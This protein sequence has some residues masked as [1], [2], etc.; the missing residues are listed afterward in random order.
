MNRALALAIAALA[1]TAQAV[2][3]DGVDIPQLSESYRDRTIN[4]RSPLAEIV[5]RGKRD[6][7]Y[8]RARVLKGKVIRFVN[9][10]TEVP[11]ALLEEIAGEFY[12][13]FHAVPEIV[14]A[15]D[16]DGSGIESGAV[17]VLESRDDRNPLVVAPDNAYASVNIA[18]LKRDFPLEASFNRRVRKEIWRALVYVLGGG[19][20]SNPHDLM[21]LNTRIADL[22]EDTDLTPS[23]STLVVMRDSIEKLQISRAGYVTYRQACLEG[24]AREPRTD[25][26]RKVRDECL[27]A[28]SKPPERPQLIKYDPKERR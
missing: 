12:G 21:R 7:G 25:L 22:D 28:R 14:T 27:E 23:P 8:V 15:D 20:S 13:L 24:W 3:Y 9:R 11:S 1:F 18:A 10:E 26:E 4:P 16:G 17:I 5:A 2:M 6:G 19:G